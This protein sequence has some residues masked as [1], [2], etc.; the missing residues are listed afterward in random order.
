MSYKIITGAN[1]AYILTLLNFLSYHVEIG[2][3]TKNIIVYDLG[4]TEDNLQKVKNFKNGDIEIKTL[5]YEQ[6]P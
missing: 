4:L 2:I 6:Y 1:N 5:T 3:K